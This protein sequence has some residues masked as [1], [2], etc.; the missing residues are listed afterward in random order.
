MHV[1]ALEADGND[2]TASVH[3]KLVHKRTKD[4]ITDQ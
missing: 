2:S 3:C 4:K 1:M